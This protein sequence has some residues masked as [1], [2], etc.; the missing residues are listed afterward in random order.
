MILSVETVKNSFHWEFLFY[1]QK[2][3]AEKPVVTNVDLSE[4]DFTEKF[5]LSLKRGKN[6]KAKK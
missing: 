1:T 4:I 3:I 2:D 6:N 5:C